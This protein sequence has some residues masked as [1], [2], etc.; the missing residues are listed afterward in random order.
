M[1]ATKC[2]MEVSSQSLSQIGHFTR[3]SI[4]TIKAPTYVKTSC[5]KRMS[6]NSS[7]CPTPF[8]KIPGIIWLL[9]KTIMFNRVRTI[10]NHLIQSPGRAKWLSGEKRKRGTERIST[11]CSIWYRNIREIQ[12]GQK[13]LVR[14]YP[15]PRGLPR[16]KYTSGG[17]IRRTRSLMICSPSLEQNTFM[18]KLNSKNSLI[19]WGRHSNHSSLISWTRS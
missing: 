7:W 3:T 8:T 1:N 19:V 10:D 6:S 14:R 16:P 15:K 12:I 4:Y 18:I 9:N 13:R 2:A 17:G 11:R 5:A